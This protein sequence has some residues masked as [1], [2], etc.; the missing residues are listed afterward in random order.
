MRK[1][2]KYKIYN[3]VDLISRFP[4]RIL[5]FKRPKWQRLK[6][7]L[8]NQTNLGIE[9]NDITIIKN[10]IKVWDKIRKSYKERLKTYSFLSAAFDNSLKIKKLKSESNITVR[11]QIYLKYIYENYYRTCS[12]LWIANIFG[13][14]FEA[15]QKIA[16]RSIFVNNK[17][18]SPSSI[19]NKGDIISVTDNNV[20]IEKI[21]KKYN[22]T[23]SVLTHVEID[24][25]SQNIV[26][27]KDKLNLSEEDFF[28]LSLDYINIQNLR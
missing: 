10:D 12:L 3:K 14:S 25:Y 7:I 8:L 4:L 24:Y 22:P 9:L 20:V 6:E 11:K 17:L 5:K 1:L 23:V 27:V 18:A 16:A 19:L 21:N 15:R 2:H 26:I 13:S 28:L